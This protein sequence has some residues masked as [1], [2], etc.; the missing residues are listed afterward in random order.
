MNI[1]SPLFF[2]HNESLISN[3]SLQEL[4]GWR[5][6][7]PPSL[8]EEYRRK[9]RNIDEIQSMI[10][11]NLDEQLRKTRHRVT[12]SI[13]QY[14]NLCFIMERMIR[15][16]RGQATDFVRYSISLK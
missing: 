2:C 4:A 11:S 14:I 10:P 12:A 8:E 13:E 7:H 6:Q 3:T 5:K 15:R 16:M 9:Q 1:L